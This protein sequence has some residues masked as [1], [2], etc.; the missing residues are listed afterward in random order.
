MRRPLI[1]GNWKMYKTI[2]EAMDFVARLKPLVADAS[3]CELVVA[4]PFT[5]LA[6]VAATARGSNVR[7]SAQDVHW[8]AEGAHTGDV[9]PRMILDAGATLAI[10]GHSERRHD[11]NETDEQVNRKLRA[12]LAAGLEPIVCVG[13][14]FEERETGRAAAVLERQFTNGF[15]GLT[16]PDFSRIIIAYEPVWAIGTGRTATPEMAAESHAKLRSLAREGFGSENAEGLRILYGG[17]VK[18]ENIR[19]LMAQPEIDGAL[20]GGASLMAESFAAIVHYR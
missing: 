14:T 3:H 4:P 5:A 19:G 11:H 20:V 15:R 18:P 8:D 16:S 7:V 10:I 6:A 1:A 12:A 17:S 9:S 2:G 13:E